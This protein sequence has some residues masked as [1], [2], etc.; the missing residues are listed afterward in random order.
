MSTEEAATSTLQVARFAR[1]DSMWILLHVQ[2]ACQ[3]ALTSATERIALLTHCVSA[4]ASDED[5]QIGSDV[6]ATVAGVA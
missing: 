4:D 5:M 1:A 2:E 6:Y 3:L